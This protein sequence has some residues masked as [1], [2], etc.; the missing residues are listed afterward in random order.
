MQLDSLTQSAAIIFAMM[1]AAETLL[2]LLPQ[3][4][5]TRTPWYTLFLPVIGFVWVFIPFITDLAVRQSILCA[6]DVES[7]HVQASFWL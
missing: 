6:K 4:H 3:I 7:T 2:I 1:G 5:T